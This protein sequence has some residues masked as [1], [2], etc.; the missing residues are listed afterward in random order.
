MNEDHFESRI[1]LFTG[2]ALVAIIVLLFVSLILVN[3]LRNNTN[4]EEKLYN[5]TNKH[6]IISVEVH[7]LNETNYVD[8]LQYMMR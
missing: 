4:L 3:Q 8:N 6:Y 2:I 1:N 7:K 5:C